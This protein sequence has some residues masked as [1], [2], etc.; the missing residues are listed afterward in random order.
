[1]NQARSVKGANKKSTQHWDYSVTQRSNCANLNFKLGPAE[2]GNSNYRP[3][4]KW[5]LNKPLFDPNEVGE[6]VFNIDMIARHIDK[7]AQFQVCEPQEFLDSFQRPLRLIRNSGRRASIWTN[8]NLPGNKQKP[9]RFNGGRKPV[10]VKLA[11]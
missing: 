11:R 3:S 8:A 1:M 4:G 6:R 10:P 2:P 5:R 7:I 9:S